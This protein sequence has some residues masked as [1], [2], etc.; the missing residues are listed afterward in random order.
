MALIVL[1]ASQVGIVAI[2]SAIRPLANVYKTIIAV[3]ILT[4]P[5]ACLADGWLFGR[6]LDFEGCLFLA[7]VHLA[8]GGFFFHFM[9]LPDRSV[10][11]R[12]LA[13]LELAPGRVLS[14][15]ALNARY[16][17]RDMIAN[18]LQQLADGRFLIL[19]AD[20]TVTLTSRGE[21]FGRFVAAGRQMFRISSAN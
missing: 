16:S 14:V 4:A 1:A 3:S 12:I 5:V 21:R 20:G 19:A 6:P 9:T 17:V 13:E 7:L 18:R 15:D 2:L 8:L 10:T 11:L